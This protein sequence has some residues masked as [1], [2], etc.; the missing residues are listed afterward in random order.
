M[1]DSKIAK[2]LIRLDDGEKGGMKREKSHSGD[3]NREI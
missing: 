1:S 2:D 3:E